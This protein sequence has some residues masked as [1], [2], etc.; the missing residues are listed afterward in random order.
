MKKP[1]L[2]IKSLWMLK[3]RS[4]FSLCVL[5]VCLFVLVFLLC[6][7]SPLPALKT[8]PKFH[9]ETILKMRRQT[10]TAK[11]PEHPG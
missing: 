5:F 11:L 6:Q 3:A 1:F 2:W 4:F 7:H 9:I 10:Q 8:D